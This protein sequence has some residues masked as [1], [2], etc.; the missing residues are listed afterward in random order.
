MKTIYV[1][2]LFCCSISA[3]A[4]DRVALVIGNATYEIAPLNNSINDAEAIKTTLEQLNFDVTLITNANKTIM[5]REINKFASNL[6]ENT[7]SLFYYAGH[8][9]QLN[10]MNYL[11]PIN[12]LSAI[13]EGAKNLLKSEHFKLFETEAIN[14]QWITNTIENRNSNI[15]IV[16][17]DACRKNPLTGS[18][19]GLSETLTASKETLI[20]YSTSPGKDAIDGPK[21]KNSPYTKALIK[22]MT[23]SNQTI[24]SILKEVA[25]TVS[26]ETNGKQIPWYT[27]NLTSSF[28]FNETGG[29][30]IEQI[31]IPKI[32]FLEGLENITIKEF[33]NGSK[34][35]GQIKNGE[36]HGKGIL[37]YPDGS[38]FEGYFINGLKEGEGRLTETNGT[39]F[40]GLFREDKR[41]GIG[42]LTWINGASMKTEWLD[43]RRV[44][45]EKNIYTGDQKWTLKGIIKHGDGL[46]EF[47][48]GA[49]YDGQFKN[50]KFN[51]WGEYVS[52]DGKLF[53]GNFIEGVFSGPGSVKLTNGNVINGIFK[54]EIAS[55]KGSIYFKSTDTTYTGN[56]LNNQA[57]GSGT[58]KNSNGSYFKGNFLKGLQHGI[59]IKF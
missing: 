30:C 16:I 4:S 1:V 12:S 52:K 22:S 49:Y 54:D 50:N 5:R 26:N 57:H 34:Y 38:K 11:L 25:S 44:Y 24:E 43:G 17:L 28:C 55:G 27:T 46:L 18:K 32:P 9:V 15:N 47:A 33:D 13:N 58:L 37:D 10:T 51:G 2:L 3:L 8:A 14:L 29:R 7:T 39:T 59:G 35:I 41:N 19:K 40:N 20:A 6:D 31:F 56:I 42:V 48:S 45:K 23:N 53:I 21:G 36:F